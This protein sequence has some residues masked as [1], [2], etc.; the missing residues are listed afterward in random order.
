MAKRMKKAPRTKKS[1][2]AR[3]KVAA[4]ISQAFEN[5]KGANPNANARLKAF[6]A[7][8]EKINTAWE[9]LKKDVK[10]KNVRA[11]LADR[12][13]LKLLLGECNYMANECK[14]HVQQTKRT[15]RSH[16]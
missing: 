6:K 10:S 2:P 9:K 1:K 5:K 4:K 15:R 14:R 12:E 11:V 8:E 7:L 16:R 3:K 13:H